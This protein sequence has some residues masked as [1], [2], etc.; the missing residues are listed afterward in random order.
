MSPDKHSDN[1]HNQTIVPRPSGEGER[2]EGE[3][4]TQLTSLEKTK[5]R[6]AD[7]H[8]VPPHLTAAAEHCAYRTEQPQNNLTVKHAVKLA[9]I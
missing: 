6:S 9:R 2:K 7:R 1:I 8:N 5:Y 4:T 3:K